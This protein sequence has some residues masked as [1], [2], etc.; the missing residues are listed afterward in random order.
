MELK[1]IKSIRRYD[2]RLQG[3]CSGTRG[4]INPAEKARQDLV[5]RGQSQASSETQRVTISK[6][7]K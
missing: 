4:L 3:E 5:A 6:K 7:G 1:S 2:Q